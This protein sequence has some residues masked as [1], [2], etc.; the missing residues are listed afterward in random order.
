M[1]FCEEEELKKELSKDTGIVTRVNRN[2]VFISMIMY[3]SSE[4]SNDAFLDSVQ[5]DKDVIINHLFSLGYYA[6][7][8]SDTWNRFENANCT[9]LLSNALFIKEV[10]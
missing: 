2:T 4:K 9:F 7:P 8:W 6:S 10:K 3:R 5:A 1:T